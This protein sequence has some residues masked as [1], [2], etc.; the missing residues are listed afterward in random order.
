M[1][2]STG[3]APVILNVEGPGGVKFT[4]DLVPAFKFDLTEL[5]IAC[6]DLHQ[7]VTEI[8]KEQKII[9]E[10]EV[11]QFVISIIFRKIIHIF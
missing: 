2:R 7:R 3:G 4:V 1:T 8:A 11:K 6:Q 5:K 10:S 9:K